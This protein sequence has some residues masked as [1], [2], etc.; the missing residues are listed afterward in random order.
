MKTIYLIAIILL[1]PSCI[2]AQETKMEIQFDHEWSLRK[3]LVTQVSIDEGKSL[4]GREPYVHSA[5]LKL[6]IN[7]DGKVTDLGFIE[8]AQ[9]D[10]F[11]KMFERMARSTSGKWKFVEIADNV[12]VVYVIIPFLHKTPPSLKSKYPKELEEQFNVYHK[13]LSFETIEGCNASNCF[14][15]EQIRNY[16]GTP[17]R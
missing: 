15:S 2:L 6:A 8:R 13:S 10:D 14:I 12:E 16:T 9:D 7:L 11:N 5:T 17:V 3:F 4:P 1:F